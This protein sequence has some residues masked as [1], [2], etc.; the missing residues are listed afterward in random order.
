MRDLTPEKLLAEHKLLTEN[1]EKYIEM[2][3]EMIDLDPTDPSGYFSRAHGW[4]RVGRLD[5]ALND[6][7]KTIA[8]KDRMT[9]RLSRGCVLVR[10]GRYREALADF[11]C[12]ESLEPGNWVDCWG[13]LHRADCYAKL[14]NEAAALAD[15][16]RLP[17]GFWSPGI[18]GEP[19][20][21][22]TE[23]TAEVRERARAAKRSP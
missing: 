6:F 2:I 13:P 17:D 3:S 7:D 23:I 11:N 16:A 18:N 15:C 14:G 9:A 12:A 19:G 21:N 10:L 20:G 22:K 8:L 4:E 5:K 1:P